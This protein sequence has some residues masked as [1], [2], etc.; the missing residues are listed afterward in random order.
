[1][2]IGAKPVL[3]T[4]VHR[5]N[6]KSINIHLAEEHDSSDLECDLSDR[7]T[8]LL[9]SLQFKGQSAENQSY[10]HF[11]KKISRQ[12]LSYKLQQMIVDSFQ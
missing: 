6:L 2:K 3:I 8:H 1:M 9:I 11:K 5:K 12:S 10:P 4:G 7:V